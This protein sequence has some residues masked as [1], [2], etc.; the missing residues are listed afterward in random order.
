MAIKNEIY[1]N[2]NLNYNNVLPFCLFY[3]IHRGI[4]KSTKKKKDNGAF[5]V[6]NILYMY[7]LI[8]PNSEDL[9]ML[10]YGRKCLEGNDFNK[11][12]GKDSS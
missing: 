2:L 6:C 4:S 5:N 7:T 12:Y 10:L 8:I 9:F 11:N 3:T 1:T